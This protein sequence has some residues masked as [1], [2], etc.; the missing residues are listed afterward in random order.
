VSPSDRTGHPRT[1]SITVAVLEREALTRAGIC[2]AL[3]QATGLEVVGDTGEYAAAAELVHHAAPAILIAGLSSDDAHVVPFFTWALRQPGAA[4]VIALTREPVPEQLLF[5]ALRAGIS[6][7]VD[8]YGDPAGLISAVR[9]VAGGGAVLAPATTRTLVRRFAGVD[10]ERAERAAELIRG[11]TDRERQVLAL[12]SEGTGNAEIGRRLHL[13][14]SAVKANVSRLL[15]K[16]NCAN[17]VQA[18]C[19]SQAADLLR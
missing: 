18:A 19:L 4:Q 6:G 8:R 14:E 1:Q 10:V 12:V 2:A 9:T 5:K 13:S 16:L 15:T 11:L 7:L 17:R 3:R